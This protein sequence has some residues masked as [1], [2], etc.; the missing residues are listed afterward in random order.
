MGQHEAERQFQ[1]NRGTPDKNPIFAG[2]FDAH[3]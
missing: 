3:I 2:F 1:I